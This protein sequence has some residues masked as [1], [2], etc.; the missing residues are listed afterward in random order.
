MT[1]ETVRDVNGFQ[2]LDV[3]H[4]EYPQKPGPLGVVLR[5]RQR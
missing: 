4:E 2:A 5:G 1:W 3:F